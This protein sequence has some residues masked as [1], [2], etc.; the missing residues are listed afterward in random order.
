MKGPGR[1]RWEYVGWLLALVGALMSLFG[2][3]G[4]ANAGDLRP[5]LPAA[6]GSRM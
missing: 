2:Q 3:P 4:E 6:A 5:E 1:I